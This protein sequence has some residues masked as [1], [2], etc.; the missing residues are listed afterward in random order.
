MGMRSARPNLTMAYPAKHRWSIILMIY[1]SHD[2]ISIFRIT[3]YEAKATLS[4]Y[5]IL[6]IL[7][8]E[9][10]RLIYCSMENDIKF[11]YNFQIVKTHILYS[12]NDELEA[13][14]NFPLFQRTIQ[15]LFVF[16]LQLIES[17]HNRQIQWQDAKI[18]NFK[19]VFSNPNCIVSI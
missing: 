15:Q 16:D 7:I 9:I 1:V 5:Y 13:N 6:Q 18:E 10:S 14:I 2:T 3:N 19:I 17:F 11:L 8:K 12:I 4:N